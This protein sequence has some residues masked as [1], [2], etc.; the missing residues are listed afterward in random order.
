MGRVG[1]PLPD[2]TLAAYVHFTSAAA[3]LLDGRL[4]ASRPYP[5]LNG[6]CATPATDYDRNN[7]IFEKFYYFNCLYNAVSLFRRRKSKSTTA[8]WHIEKTVHNF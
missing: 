2:V 3:A 5:L 4:S 6:E 8:F 7:S 1:G